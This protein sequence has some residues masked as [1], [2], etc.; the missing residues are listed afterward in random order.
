MDERARGIERRLEWPMLLAALL[1]IPAIA[2]EQTDTG[3]PWGTIATVLN[4]TTWSAFAAEVAIMTWVVPDRR[5]WLRDHPLELAI[6]VLTPPFLP[7]SLQAARAF[8]LLRL[9]PLLMLVTLTRRLL[10]TEGIRD[11][12]VLA[13]MTILGGGAAFAAIE[14]GHHSQP[15]STW[16]GV[17]W[18]ITTVTT[19]GY[20]DV[21]PQTDAGRVVAIVVML[22]GIGFIAVLTAAAASRFLREQRAEAMALEAVERRL[23]EV[24]RRL[25][26]M[27]PAG[28]D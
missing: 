24:L 22:V 15:V 7:A 25:D 18:A 20:G 19:V 4:W 14:N 10:S 21:S 6:V 16:D 28:R 11:A 26:A 1:T 13:T 12:G 9:L 5:R 27:A 17:W 8:R 2:I 3:E 23:D